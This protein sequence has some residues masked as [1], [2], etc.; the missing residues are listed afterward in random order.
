MVVKVTVNLK[1]Q[2]EANLKGNHEVS[3]IK[4][5]ILTMSNRE[6]RNKVIKHGISQQCSNDDVSKL[7]YFLST[8][9]AM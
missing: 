7:I 2:E 9:P 4:K 3:Q 6:L 8:I 5:I 1:Y